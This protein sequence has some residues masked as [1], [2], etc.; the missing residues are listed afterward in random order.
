[1]LKQKDLIP[2]EWSYV[3]ALCHYIPFTEEYA[4]HAEMLLNDLDDMFNKAFDD[5]E[6]VTVEE[7]RKLAKQD[8]RF[9]KFGTCDHCGARFN[10]GAVFKN[11]NGEHLVVGNTCAR[12]NMGLTAQEYND[13][14]M[15]KLVAGARTRAKKKIA[16]VE[17]E[18]KIKTLP[19]ELQDALNYEHNYFCK[20]IRANF[21]EWG[22]LSEKQIE[23]V[24]N[25]HK[26]SLE[27]NKKDVDILEN[28]EELPNTGDRE[29]YKGEVIG[30]K[31]VETPSFGYGGGT[32]WVTKLII[33]E[34]RGF[35][36]FGSA[37]NKLDDY[38]GEYKGMVVQFDAKA[39]PAKGDAYFGYYKRPTK[40]KVFNREHKD[41][42]NERMHKENVENNYEGK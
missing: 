27:Q 4:E 14:R 41:D 23:A 38:V 9:A 37:P 25:A 28:R 7:A 40:I 1:M 11:S 20:N 8:G 42:Y 12:N 35:K 34:E 26:T 30:V 31:N 29:T 39:T 3:S 16:R 21:I 17:N 32:T 13:K 33:L 5:E 2:Q 18:A 36:L 22:N 15:R 10:Y 24:I 19:Q 6:Y